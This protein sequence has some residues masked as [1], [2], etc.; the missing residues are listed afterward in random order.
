MPYPTEA[1]LLDTNVV[2]DWLCLSVVVFVG[3]RAT[4]FDRLRF[5]LKVPVLALGGGWVFAAQHYLEL[6]SDEERQS[7][8]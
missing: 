3:H 2:A 5:G 7:G 4:V 6:V 1:L 8:L